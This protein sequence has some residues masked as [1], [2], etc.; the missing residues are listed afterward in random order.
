MLDSIRSRRDDSH[1]LGSPSNKLSSLVDNA[2]N[3]DDKDL[4]NSVK[5]TFK[6]EVGLK[7]DTSDVNIHR[8]SQD[9][10]DINIDSNSSSDKSI[11][12]FFSKPDVGAEEVKSRFSNLFGQITQNRRDSTSPQISQIGLQPGSPNLS[13]LNTKPSISNLLD[14]TAALFDDYDEDVVPI[15]KIDKGKAKE[16]DENLLSD[17][18]ND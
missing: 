16:V 12:Q 6:E 7:V 18:I 10:P 5:E 1:V 2:D 9:L 4:M 3:L 17:V 11:N 13:P 14:D 8:S 15:S